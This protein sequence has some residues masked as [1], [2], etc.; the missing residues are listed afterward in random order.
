MG[1]IGLKD[2]KHL[3]NT[4]LRKISWFVKRFGL[5][6]VFMK[7]L[8]MIFAPIIISLKKKRSFKFEGKLYTLFYHRYNTTWAS[9]RA[10]EI[11]IAK[12]FVDNSKGNILEIG[13]VLSHYFDANWDVLDKF[14]RGEKVI[15]KDVVNFKPDKKY[16][17]IVSLSTFEHIGYDDDSP[18]NSREKIIKAF[19]N[20][21]KNC[22]KKGGRFLMSVPIN[23]NPHMDKLV[24]K[25]AF[26][27]QKQRFVKRFKRDNWREVSKEEA[28]K[29]KYGRPFPYANCVFF[30]EYKK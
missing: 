17:N 30:G 29:C 24:S 28:M 8:R 14:E 25:N 5:S 2:R 11:P 12:T 23:Y 16:D 18:T 20:V 1:E 22:L 19:N 7:P 6:Q 9:E 13:N 27:F 15:N 26:G 3:Y 4:K 21:K 10:V